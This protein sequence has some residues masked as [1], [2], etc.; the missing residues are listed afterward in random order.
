[1]AEEILNPKALEPLYAPHEEPNKHR[2]KGGEVKS[3]RRPSPL[4]IAQNI[5]GAVREWRE[6]AYPGASNT[7]LELLEH[8][9]LRAH[10]VKAKDGTEFP[11]N[12]YFCQREAIE[13]FIFLKEVLRRERISALVAEFGGYDA[14]TIALGV[15]PETDLWAK[16]AFK[17]A[18]GS[19]K[20]KV[21]SLAM[22]WSYFHALR[23]NDSPMAK[24]F[25]VIAPN[26]TVFERLKV[27]FAPSDGGPDVFS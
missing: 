19:G 8:W 16:Y 17:M 4:T 2:I 6:N 22:V 11:F 26:I 25:V 7:T 14:E 12:Y 18:T 3:G 10:I 24:H 23:E 9:F 1:M 20:T 13:T 5:R 21:M 27:D 15:D